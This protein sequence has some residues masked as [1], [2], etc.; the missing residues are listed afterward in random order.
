[1]WWLGVEAADVV[2]E[3]DRQVVANLLGWCGRG[4]SL[5]ESIDVRCVD[6]LGD[7]TPSELGQQG[8]HAAHQPGP[9]V[10]DVGVALG[11]ESQHL[12][13]TDRFHP[14]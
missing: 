1:M 4:D 10:A 7:P 8:V 13:M 2:E 11:Q 6:F 9:L 3:L 14:S 12:A 5:E